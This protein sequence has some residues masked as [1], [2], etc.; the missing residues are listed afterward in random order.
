[1]MTIFAR[2]RRLSL[3]FRYRCLLTFAVLLPTLLSGVAATWVHA[4]TTWDGG[5]EVTLD[6]QDMSDPALPTNRNHIGLEYPGRRER[7]LLLETDGQ[8]AH[9]GQ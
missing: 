9:T 3:G 8:S 6:N 5:V 4:Q 7:N 2:T 1:M